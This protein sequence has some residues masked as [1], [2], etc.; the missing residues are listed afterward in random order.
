MP[1]FQFALSGKPA[2]QGSKNA[3]NRGGRIVLVESS[4]NLPEYRSWVSACAS[5]EAAAQG[6]VKPERDTPIEVIIGFQLER[7]ATVRRPHPTTPPDLDKL[8]RAV[9]D[10]IT[11]AGNVW[12][13]DSQVTSL[14]S[15]KTYATAGSGLTIVKVGYVND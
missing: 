13:D 9:L 14:V 5:D 4:K 6:W 10:G 1:E 3:Y 2:P 7:P 15:H 12:H 8:I 11:Q